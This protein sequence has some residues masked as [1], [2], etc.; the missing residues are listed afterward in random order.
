MSHKLQETFN[1]DERPI[2]AVLGRE[3]SAAAGFSIT[4]EP[5]P[6]SAPGT[7]Y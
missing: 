6:T 2:A 7:M 4:N 5:A 3:F 1:N